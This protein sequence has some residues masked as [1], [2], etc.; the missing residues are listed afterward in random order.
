MTTKTQTRTLASR[1]LK[2]RR[3]NF[4]M[5]TAIVFPV[6]LAAGGVAIDLTNMVMIKANLQDAADSA[7][8]AAASA[9]ANDGK[10][11][12][13]A[14]LIALRFL[15][16]QMISSSTIDE[17]A[18]DDADDSKNP[19]D[20][21]SSTIVDIKETPTSGSGMSYKVDISAKYN[22]QFNAFTR[23]LGQTST[24]LSAKSTA[25]SATES[26]N[27]LSMFLV[28][29]RS[30]SMSFKTNEIASQ[31]VA[32]KNWT[33]DNWQQSY[34]RAETPCYLRKIGSLKKAVGSLAAEM[35]RLDPNKELVRTAAV[36]YNDM[37]QT[38]TKLNWG[39]KGALDYVNALPA[40]PLGGTDSHAAFAK[41]L[42]KLAPAKASD[43]TENKAHKDKNGQVPTKYII[44]M[45]D[46]ENTHYNGAQS[47]AYAKK[48]D[49]DT[50]ASC[51]KAKAAGVIIYTVAFL[52]PQRGKEL[53]QACA[54]TFTSEK[55]LT[56]HYFEAEDTSAL[57]SAFKE[58]GERTA[59]VVSRL[60]K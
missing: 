30:G 13:D 59:A 58:I 36:S 46:G 44:F 52:A 49:D 10:K 47:A 7:A 40:E 22:V 39:T 50:K 41:A 6:M 17:A 11:A 1:L 34:V 4:A 8:L 57:I 2:D 23:L 14:K 55:D 43:E 48:S 35:D 3:G 5:M 24:T 60:S 51:V 9:L 21:D 38:E 42:E 31:S 45:T 15:K 25:E 27:A 16:T 32:C 12:A 53:L 54:H 33:S 19:N 26:K 18:G 28:L 20:F 29:D 56:D 37:M